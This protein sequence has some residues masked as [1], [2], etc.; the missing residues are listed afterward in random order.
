MLLMTQCHS[1]RWWRQRQIVTCDVV[2]LSELL[3]YLYMPAL[4]KACCCLCNGCNNNQS[5]C[6]SYI[7]IVII[8]YWTPRF[9]FITRFVFFWKRKNHRFL[10][11]LKFYCTAFRQ[12][13]SVSLLIPSK[14]HDVVSF[15]H[16]EKASLSETANTTMCHW[17][18]PLILAP[19][20]KC[21]GI[22]N[23]LLT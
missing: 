23:F 17:G 21:E 2:S 14:K 15:W 11:F 4:H 10:V 8:C 22:L 19:W 3:A 1:F 7:T 5:R 16:C 20:Y 13:K 9:W 12:K 6:S 18:V